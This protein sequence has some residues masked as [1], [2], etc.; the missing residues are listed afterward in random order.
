MA[1]QAVRAEH[2][3]RGMGLWG[4]LSANLL[5]MVGVGPFL[6]IP[7]ALAA[8]GGPQAMLGWIFGAVL[9]LC[10]GMVWAELG[11]RMPD[12]GGSYHYLSQAF[13][14]NSAGR[15]ISFLFLWQTLLIG[16]ISIASG[17]VGFAEY[18]SV[19]HPFSPPQLKMIA[20]VLC[21][22]N[23]VV[24]Y[25]PIRS[26]GTLSVVVMT[27]VVATCCWIIFA[28]A[29]HFHPALAFDFPPHAFHPS[30]SFWIGLGSAVLIATYDYG[31]YNN[32]CYIGGEIKN[33]R[34]N[35]PRAVLI[36]ILFVAALYLAMNIAILSVL[37]WREAMHSKAIV[38]DFI[39]AIYGSYAAKLASLLILVASWGSAYAILL[40]YSRIPYAAAV[41]G[42]FPG[43]F[44]RIHPRGHFPTTSLI[45][46]GIGSALMCIFSLAEL[47]SI[48]IVIQTLLQS[49]AQCIAV[50]L[51][52]RRSKSDP[53][54]F[55]MPFYPLPVAI[56]LVGWVYI[57]ATSEWKHVAV[58]V[59]LAASGVGFYLIQA[60]KKEEW[61]FRQA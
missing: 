16:P 53:E 52:R 34:R 27:A 60:R 14:P 1:N 47:I 49:I 42:Q 17:A 46:M 56:A 39:H 59:V 4:A 21:L 19:F 61:P 26:I 18:S 55:R 57:I 35:I 45:Y 23:L 51:L 24:L 33:P 20:I 5:N 28:G 10:D 15:L 8:M 29:S 48:L 6:T 41:D 30:R 36:S 12:S 31:G 11:S 40:G 44:A 58:G 32:V 22:L 43:V 7:L 25:R 54:L 50:V 9:A 3:E 38:A 37:P 2:L 13:G